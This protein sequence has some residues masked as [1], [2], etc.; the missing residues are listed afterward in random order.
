MKHFTAL[1]WTGCVLFASYI[2]AQPQFEREVNPFF[3]G[4]DPGSAL[5]QPFLGGLNMPAPQFVDIDNDGDLD[6]FVHEELDR[7]VFLRNEGTANTPTFVLEEDQFLDIRGA[8]WSRFVDV[9][10]D[11]DLDLCIDFS[12]RVN[13]YQNT[14]SAESGSWELLLGSLQTPNGDFVQTD[15]ISTPDFTDI[16]GDGDPDLMVGKQNGR[17]T[18]Y[19]YV[20]LNSDQKPVFLLKTDFFSEIEIILDGKREKTSRHGANALH[21]FDLNQ[22]G[23]LDLFWGDFFLGGIAYLENVGNAS[24]P[25][26]DNSMLVENF[27]VEDP[28]VSGGYNVPWLADINDDALPDLFVGI[29]GGNVSFLES[30]EDNFMFYL[31]S[32]TPGQPQFN[33]Q[34]R[35]YL[36]GLDFGQ[37]ST[38]LLHDVDDDGDLDLF[39]A[40]QEDL[41]APDAGNSRIHFYRNTGSITEPSLSLEDDHLLGRDV[42]FENN[43]TPALADLDG[44]ND[45][46]M[47]LGSWNGAMLYYR[48]I[49]TLAN[50]QFVEADAG[51]LDVVI[52]SHIAPVLHDVDNDGDVDLF[53]GTIGG[54][55]HFYENTGSGSAPLFQLVTQSFA[56]ILVGSYSKPAFVDING[57]G[58]KDLLV[59]S[60]LQG[61]QLYRNIGGPL[62]FVHDPAFELPMFRRMAPAAG[63]LDGD[64]D[65]DLLTGLSAG[66]LAYF[67]NVSEQGSRGFDIE[68]LAF[69]YGVVEVGREVLFSFQIINPNTQILTFDDISISGTDAGRFSV[70]DNAIN[71]LQLGPGEKGDLEIAF[72]PQEDLAYSAELVLEVGQDRLAIPI[73]GKGTVLRESVAVLPNFPNPLAASTT[74]VY[75]L[76][77]SDAERNDAHEV[78]IF[79]TLGQKIRYW[80]I[81]NS[82]AGARNTLSWDARNEAGIPVA[83]GIYFCVLKT[84]RGEIASRKLVVLR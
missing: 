30:I 19:E 56:N 6:L 14:G 25:N 60:L 22:D 42:Q 13:L 24:T 40:A 79:N 61:T 72:R 80:R 55:V 53:C 5:D 65:P 10:G 29:Y 43:L 32:G 17:I 7:V 28:V 82:S 51:F 39:V 66:G 49:G 69:D 18:W 33:Q 36:D 44:D 54:N 23:D 83:S 34:T 37:H 68:P 3:V 31:N 4:I 75:S 84:S 27:P 41:S 21:F 62:E 71:D 52:G 1:I 64:G 38:P 47:I 46:D 73:A 59:G 45:P 26:F 12:G 77:I 57:D 78:F 8:S 81:S 20:S 70:A 58:D 15:G 76:K 9:D 74:L 63:D 11:G 67:R 35:R 48:N 16:D 2:C 50:P